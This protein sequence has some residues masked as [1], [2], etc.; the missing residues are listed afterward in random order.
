MSSCLLRHMTN[1]DKAAYAIPSG[2]V[3]SVAFGYYADTTIALYIMWKTL[4]VSCW[5]VV[6]S[7][8]LTLNL[9]DVLQLGNRKRLRTKDSGLHRTIVLCE[10]GITLPCGHTGTHESTAKLL[11]V[12]AFHLRRTV[13]FEIYRNSMSVNLLISDLSIYRISVMDRS[14]FDV[15]GLNTSGQIREMSKLCNTAQVLKFRIEG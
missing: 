6:V 4:Q 10:H 9:S 7:D 14:G 12:P 15:Y 5:T 13:R 3:A 8:I 2:L 11:E 1:T